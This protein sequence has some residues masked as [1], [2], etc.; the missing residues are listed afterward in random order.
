MAFAQMMGGPKFAT[1]SV[2]ISPAAAKPGSSV[3]LVLAIDIAAGYHI[4]SVKPH[5]PDLIATDVSVSSVPG[6]NIGTPVYPIA[7]TL[8]E[9]G[10]ST[11]LSVYIGQANIIVPIAVPAST[12]PGKYLVPVTLTYQGCDSNSCFPPKT[13]NLTASLLVK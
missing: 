4:N 13:E 10:S 8:K 6:L 1:T 7:K 9:A 11:P 12:K 2:H 3:K 5:D